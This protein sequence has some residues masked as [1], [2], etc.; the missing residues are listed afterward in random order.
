MKKV[1]HI[2]VVSCCF[3]LSL[4]GN[5]QSLEP[6]AFPESLTDIAAADTTQQSLP[7]EPQILTKFYSAEMCEAINKLKPLNKKNPGFHKILI[8][9]E[10]YPKHTPLLVEMKRPLSQSGDKFVKVTSFKIQD[11]GTYF[12]ENHEILDYILGTSRGF[13]PGEKV[14]VRIK[15]ADGSI[16][17]EVT[18]T[19]NPVVSRDSKGVIVASAEILS[20]KPTT[21]VIDLPTATEGEEIEVVATA[22]GQTSKSTFKYTKSKPFHYSPYQTDKDTGGHGTLKIKRKSGDVYTL[23]LPWGAALEPYEKGAKSYPYQH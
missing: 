11:D 3:T 6:E 21:Y 7:S 8:K 16:A 9:V 10:G 20:K 17:K 4:F 2:L 14:T 1:A 18:G 12:T 15:T 5:A 19:P 23:R 13:M 22:M